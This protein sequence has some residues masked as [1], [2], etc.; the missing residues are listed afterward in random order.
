M[1]NTDQE[2]EHASNQNAESSKAPPPPTSD[3][4]NGE[5][6][7]GSGRGLRFW[8]FAGIG[9]SIALCL[10]LALITF[11]IG[12]LSGSWKDLASMVTIIRDLLIILMV[13]QGILIG[14]ALIVMISQF[15]ILLNILQNEINP[16]VDSTQQTADTV[17]G[18]AQ[19]L[20]KH[21]SEPVIQITSFV[22][23][24][25]AFMREILG[26]RR[27]LRGKPPA[28]RR[29]QPEPEDEAA[30]WEEFAE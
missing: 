26:I 8:I 21:V 12:V 2:S 5:E 29:N 24:V 28:Q 23:G 16:I 6:D 1:L 15:S 10:L 4:E 11:G 20:S 17:K 25:S 13:L 3:A 30:I 22:A 18:T 7:E 14:V 9:G 27:A 19:F